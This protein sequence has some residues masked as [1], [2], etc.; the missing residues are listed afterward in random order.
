MIFEYIVIVFLALIRKSWHLVPFS[1][2]ETS[3]LHVCIILS[4]RNVIHLLAKPSLMFLE[5]SC[6]AKIIKLSACFDFSVLS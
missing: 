4:K 6:I 1:G 2:S 3:L 5:T